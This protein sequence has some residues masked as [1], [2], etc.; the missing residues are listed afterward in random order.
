VPEDTD[1]RQFE[2]VIQEVCE[3]IFAKPLSEI[4][5]GQFLVKLFDTARRFDME[6]Q[7]QLV[8][9]QKTLRRTDS[10]GLRLRLS[11]RFMEPD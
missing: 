3:P 5:F 8:L 9:L 10:F 1:A 4:S 11:T 7:P 2:R 6:I